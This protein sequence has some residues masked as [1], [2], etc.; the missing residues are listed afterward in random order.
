[1]FYKMGR[2]ILRLNKQ[3]EKQK[4]ENYSYLEKREK[5]F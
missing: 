2:F 3:T 4:R 5:K 1:M